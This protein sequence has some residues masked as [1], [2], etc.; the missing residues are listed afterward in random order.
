MSTNRI[1]LITGGSRGLGRSMV[2]ALAD[3]GV[4]VIFTFHANETEAKAVVKNVEGKGRKAVAL[5]LDLRQS[6]GF[7]AFA[8]RVK[9]VLQER[10]DRTHFEILVNNAGTGLYAPYAETTEAQFDE[11]FNVHLKSTFFLTQRLLPL[12]GDGGR[13]LNVSTGLARFSLPGYAA[14]GTMKGGVETLTRYMAR[15]LASRKIT[16]NVLAPGAIETDFGGG[17]VRDDKATN[18][19]VAS[20]TAMGRVG[21]PQDIGPAVAALV[22]PEL[23]WMTAQ[24]I[25]LSGGT[26]I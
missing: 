4:D 13:V 21:L 7:S 9:G 23:G 8:E 18:Q 15:E 22:S 6:A 24:R 2:E 26:L 11:M 10:F 3:H 16:V 25:E 5:Q 17:R 14:Y 19:F 12:L 20:M 1:A